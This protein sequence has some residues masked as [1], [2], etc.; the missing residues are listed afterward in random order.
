MCCVC[1]EVYYIKFND[2]YCNQVWPVRY[3]DSS[4]GGVHPSSGH[5]KLTDVMRTGRE[6]L[7]PPTHEHTVSDQTS[8][9]KLFP[10]I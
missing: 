3:F 10:Q 5:R 1:S 7:C 4:H 6:G 8:P 2:K 9:A